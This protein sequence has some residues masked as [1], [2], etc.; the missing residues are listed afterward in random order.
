[1]RDSRLDPDRINAMP[2]KTL[3]I[4]I[5]T[6]DVSAKDSIFDLID[7][8]VDAYIRNGLKERREVKLTISQD[9]FAIRDNC[10]GIERDF[11]MNDVFRF[12]V[13]EL[14][15]KKPTLGIYGLGLKRALLKI[16]RN[17]RMETDDLTTNC[18]V[19]WDV[20]K[21]K[22]IE[23]TEEEAWQ[24]PFET[25]QSQLSA[26]DKGY[27]KIS[28]TNLDK[29]IQKAFDSPTFINDIKRFIRITYTNFMR[30]NI[31]FLVNGRVIP[32]YEIR[33]RC[34]G[35]YRPAKIRKSIGDVNVTVIC[36]VDPREAEKKRARIEPEKRGWNVFFNKRLL[37]AGD[38]TPTTGWTGTKGKLP[39]YHS[40]FNEFRGFVYIDSE[41]TSKLPVNTAKNGLNTE[42][43]VYQEVLNLMINTAK[44]VVDYLTRKYPKEKEELDNIEREV[45]GAAPEERGEPTFISI[46]EV[47]DGSRFGAPARPG[48]RI[49]VAKI[50]YTRERELVKKVRERLKV[51]TNREA[52]EKTFDYYVRLEGIKK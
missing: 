39:K 17:I 48:P 19:E 20:D 44:P 2:R 28:I 15:E 16:G 29:Q 1:M 35:K 26:H 11:L 50:S 31:S 46:D 51:E 3:F 36:F 25:R 27:T 7:N 6:R 52:G 14:G 12:G 10:G 5:L 34:D 24:I 8:S 23:E 9:K 40:L 21:W 43:P 33:A 13:E 18:K 42:T 32:P 49:T 30:K 4:D 22:E 47:E 37:L 45:E 38:T 41:D